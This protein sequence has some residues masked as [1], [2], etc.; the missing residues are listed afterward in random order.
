MYFL[1]QTYLPTDFHDSNGAVLTQNIDLSSSY[2]KMCADGLCESWFEKLNLFSQSLRL[3][4]DKTRRLETLKRFGQTSSV[5]GFLFISFG[6][7]CFIFSSGGINQDSRNS[8]KRKWPKSRWST[9]HPAPVSRDRFR[10]DRI[11]DRQL[12]PSWLPRAIYFCICQ[13]CYYSVFRWGDLH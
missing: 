12:L 1:R 9:T 13:L 5:Y 11:S 7:F 6:L 4:K 2:W 10:M 3:S 8:R